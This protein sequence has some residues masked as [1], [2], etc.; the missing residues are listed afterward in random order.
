M[1]VQPEGAVRWVELEQKLRQERPRQWAERLRDASSNE[2]NRHL[3]IIARYATNTQI[4]RLFEILMKEKGQHKE[5]LQRWYSTLS[6]L[7]PSI[8]SERTRYN[9]VVSERE[10]YWLVR[11]A[12][13]AFN[14]R[15]INNGSNPAVVG[16][17]GNAGLLMAPICCILTTLAQTPY[18][19]IVVRRR[20]KESY[21]SKNG[22]LLQSISQH[23][24]SELKGQLKRSITLGTSSGGL[25]GLCIAHA[26]RL[27]LGIAIGAGGNSDTFLADGPVAQASMSP[28]KREWSILPRRHKSNLM[29]TASAGH[30]ADVTSARLI[31]DHFNHQHR[32]SAKAKALL[33]PECSSHNL[34]DALSVNGITL[35]QWL[36]PLIQEDFR[37]LPAHQEHP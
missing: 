8:F 17:T 24:Q 12:K 30:D 16:F 34:L 14:P 13:A 4:K 29:L 23:L 32:H 33:F 27:P 6:R 31:C 18:D 3:I 7:S 10:N 2:C 5:S 15:Q 25:A 19:L 22:S 37:R 20:H 11:Y 28:R 35:D 21:F 36:L 26:L 1:T 9:S